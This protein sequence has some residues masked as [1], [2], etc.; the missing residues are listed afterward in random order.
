LTGFGVVNVGAAGTFV[1]RGRIGQASLR[2][3]ILR[4]LPFKAELMICPARESIDLA[5]GDADGTDPPE[6]A[7]RERDGE[8]ATEAAAPSPRLARRRPWE[9]RVIRVSGRYA[10]SHLPHPGKILTR[11]TPALMQRRR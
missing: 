1:V 9:V 10:V 8:T 4:R 2:A 6:K 5:R 7:V 11:A 3:E